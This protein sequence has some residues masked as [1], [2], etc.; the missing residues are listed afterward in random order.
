MKETLRVCSLK[1]K[2]KRWKYSFTTKKKK[3]GN[4]VIVLCVVDLKIECSSSNVKLTSVL[5]VNAFT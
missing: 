4:I 5:V 2:D 3:D 1:N